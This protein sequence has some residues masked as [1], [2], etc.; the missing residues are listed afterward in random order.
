MHGYTHQIVAST[1]SS[2]L[3][4][5]RNWV[6]T[7]ARPTNAYTR[8]A[9]SFGILW[10]LADARIYIQPENNPSHLSYSST[11]TVYAAVYGDLANHTLSSHRRHPRALFARFD[12]ANS[13]F[14]ISLC[15]VYLFCARIHT[16][17][18][19][20]VTSAAISMMYHS[21]LIQSSPHIYL[22]MKLKKKN[23]CYSW[24]IGFYIYKTS[25]FV[26]AFIKVL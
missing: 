25:N 23:T 8:L 16:D 22:C 6:S 15:V 19:A 11:M 20:L 3:G 12:E 5:I 26:V 24:I 7:A 10:H 2:I 17:R 9:R 14:R 13:M 4:S 18:V 1:S 21:T